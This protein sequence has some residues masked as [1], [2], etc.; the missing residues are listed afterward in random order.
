MTKLKNILFVFLFIGIIFSCA[1]VKES[2]YLSK[3]EK[4]EQINT[5]DKVFFIST[6]SI[7]RIKPGDQLYVTVKSGNDEPNSFNQTGGSTL[8]Y[9]ELLTYLVDNDG[10]IRIPYL[11][12]LKVE[13]LTMK[14]LV[15][16]LEKEL[17]QY[18]YLPTISV[19][20]IN[21][22]ITILGE[23]NT[24][25]I[26]IYNSNTLNIFQAIAH[27]GDIAAYGNRKKVTIIRQEGET[28]MKKQINLLNDEVIASEWYHIQPDDIIYVEPL[29]RK[30]WGT[31]T[32]SI[33]SWLSLV[34]T[35]VVTYTLLS[36][37][38]L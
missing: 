4:V 15:E 5:P 37:T 20:I 3:S 34:S 35:L 33:F 31:Q 30:I 11:N 6:D 17:T 1:P 8:Q 25:G 36:G 19:R 23:V 32:F 38:T 28:V 26:Y 29:G 24:P 9:P 10:E 21:S 7:E 22:R 27:A 16:V 12:T 13:N 2:M 14:E 18:I